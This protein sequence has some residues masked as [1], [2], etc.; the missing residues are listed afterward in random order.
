MENNA[1]FNKSNKLLG[2]KKY[3]AN[4]IE[5]KITNNNN[6]IILLILLS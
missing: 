6:G 3:P 4:K 2:K 5:V 1:D